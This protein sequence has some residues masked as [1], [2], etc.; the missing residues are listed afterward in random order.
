MAKFRDI[1]HV[2]CCL[3]LQPL[4]EH[5][6]VVIPYAS[7][8]YPLNKVREPLLGHQFACVGITTFDIRVERPSLA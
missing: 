8:A 1:I 7:L 5:P 3:G 4:E 6:I 2:L